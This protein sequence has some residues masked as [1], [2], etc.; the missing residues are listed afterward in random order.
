M[1][2]GTLIFS[3]AANL[4]GR[5]R[6]SQYKRIADGMLRVNQYNDTVVRISSRLKRRSM[7]PSESLQLR[8]LSTIHAARPTAESL[9]AGPRACWRWPASRAYPILQIDNVGLIDRDTEPLD[10]HFASPVVPSFNPCAFWRR[11]RNL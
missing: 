3:P 1:P 8:N 6:L 7:S 10:F 2:T 5:R 4:K 9:S 11:R